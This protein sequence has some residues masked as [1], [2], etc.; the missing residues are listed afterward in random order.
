SEL[1]SLGRSSCHGGP[2]LLVVSSP[3]AWTLAQIPR[4]VYRRLAQAEFRVLVRIR[5]GLDLEVLGDPLVHV[6]VHGDRLIALLGEAARRA[7]RQPAVLRDHHQT[8][9]LLRKLGGLTEL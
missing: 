1:R 4:A 7:R 8:G 6:A 5:R 9:S 2:S 3:L